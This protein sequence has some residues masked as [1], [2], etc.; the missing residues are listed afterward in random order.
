MSEKTKKMD[1]RTFLKKTGLGSASSLLALSAGLT[2]SASAALTAQSPVIKEVEMPTRVLGKTGVP[3]SV[4]SLGGMIDFTTDSILLRMA[5]KMGVNYWDTAHSYANG[6]SEIGIGNYF[7]KNPG[8]RKKIFLTTKSSGKNDPEGMTERLEISLSRLKT[9]YIDLYLM[10]GLKDPD[11]LTPEISAWADGKKKEGKIRFFG[12]STHGNMARM[13]LHASGQGFI[14]AIMATYNTDVMEDD[15]MKA[16]V[17]ACAKAGIGLVAMKTQG[18]RFKLL[19]SSAAASA[20][21]S[22]MN[23]GYTLEQAKLKAVWQ[24][25]RIAAICSQM[26]N[27]AMLRDNAAAASDGKKLT[28]RDL[29]RLQQLAQSSCHLYCRG[30]MQCEIVMGGQT[31]IP[32]VL[33]QMMYYNAYGEPGVARQQFHEIPEY[34]RKNIALIDF[35]P[36]ERV[37]PNQIEIGKIMKEA[38]VLLA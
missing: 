12:F 32:D 36:A 1:R 8:D 16:A 23:A 14:D 10:H 21:E 31:R 25:Q 11:T 29:N 20:T 24:D 5:L 28:G 38:A 33:R 34:I 3:V 17:D 9:D 19:G 37:C 35:A 2:G 13:L 22:F 30:C 18:A 15:D 26:K 7:E 4:L 27:M 6:Q